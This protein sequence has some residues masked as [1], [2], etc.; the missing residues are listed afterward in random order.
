MPRI[1]KEQSRDIGACPARTRERRH[2]LVDFLSISLETWEIS[3]TN[4]EIPAHSNGP[5]AGKHTN[6]GKV[7]RAGRDEA[8]NRRDPDG[9]IE[10]K[11]AAEDIAPKAPEH[12]SEQQA[13][14][15]RQRQ[16]RRPRSTEFGGD[17]GEDQRGYDGPEIVR[18]PAEAH[19]DEELP[20]IASHSNFLDCDI[21]DIRFC[22]IHWIYTLQDRW[23]GHIGHCRAEG[24]LASISLFALSHIS[25]VG[26]E[27]TLQLNGLW[28]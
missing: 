8:E 23:G 18:G 11:P 13:D 20:L 21:Q 7:G 10:G 5:K 28:M 3:L 16:Q 2:Y 4:R 22:F 6:G 9:Q 25:V 17:G 15:L 27:Q 24:I 14:V 12:G 19:D 1:W 26:L